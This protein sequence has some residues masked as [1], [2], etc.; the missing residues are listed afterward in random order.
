MKMIGSQKSIGMARFLI[1][2]SSNFQGSVSLVLSCS[3]L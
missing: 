3:K 2:T 1:C